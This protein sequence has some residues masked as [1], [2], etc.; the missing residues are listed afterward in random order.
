MMKKIYIPLIL[1][2]FLFILPL[3]HSEPLFSMCE[4]NIIVHQNCTLVTPTLGNCS[5]MDYTIY[6]ITG[7]EL[8]SNDLTPFAGGLYY[9]NF[10]EPKGN[11]LVKLC[12]G[13]TREV[14]VGEGDDKM[15]VGFIILLPMLLGIILIW[16]AST[17][18]EEH[19]A[20]KIGLFVLSFFSFVLSM[21]L[22]MVSIVKFY[23][24]P[25]MQE[26]LAYT[27]NWYLWV[28]GFIITYIILYIIIIGM[29][30]AKQEKD[31]KLK[32]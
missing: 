26:V 22:S 2:M 4:D 20:L 16:A 14:I 5:N 7:E 15:I 23:D 17:L 10:T 18:G 11:Y 6:N 28:V 8:Q 1:S 21:H 13:T 25:E 32:Y 29:R 31:N 27:S 19:V 12:D 24:W 9:I 3:I 30:I